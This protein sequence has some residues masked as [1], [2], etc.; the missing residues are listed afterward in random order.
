MLNKSETHVGRDNIEVEQ[1]GVG[2]TTHIDRSIHFHNNSPFNN[3]GVLKE[4]V[5]QI[6][7]ATNDT[8]YSTFICAPCDDKSSQEAKDI[9]A[10]LTDKLHQ[11]NIEYIIGGGKELLEMPGPYPHL[12]E[13]DVLRN[14]QCNTLIIIADNYS[15]F[16]QLSSL[17]QVKF[18]NELT[19][20]EIIAFC[21]NDVLENES[22]MREG[23]IAFFQSVNK[24]TL[25]TFSDVSEE[26]IDRIVEGIST[27]KL[28]WQSR[29]RT[30]A[31]I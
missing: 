4:L 25:M 21:R 14:E 28:F 23:P 27:H 18:D 2:N 7:V 3:E 22:F 30:K 26:E 15:T 11:K 6:T 31:K 13:F 16:S 1:G 29:T 9:F 17:S 19:S 12:N 8:K 24:G 10:L 5:G 20:L